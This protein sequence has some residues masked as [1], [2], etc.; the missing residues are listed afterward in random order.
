MTLLDDRADFDELVCAL[1]ERRVPEARVVQSAALAFVQSGGLLRGGLA[2]LGFRAL[3]RCQDAATARAEILECLNAVARE[4]RD[5]RS[6]SQ[7]HARLQFLVRS[8]SRGLVERADRAAELAC[9]GGLLLGDGLIRRWAGGQDTRAAWSRW[10]FDRLVAS[11][12]PAGREV[13]PDWPP[14]DFGSHLLA[15]PEAIKRGRLPELSRALLAGSGSM[16]AKARV[17]RKVRG[18]SSPSAG[19]EEE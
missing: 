8:L 5:R 6:S 4:I 11:T 7:Q 12:A 1:E 15:I 10:A 19:P 18:L 2:S 3:V 14:G 13:T 9:L 16:V 17:L